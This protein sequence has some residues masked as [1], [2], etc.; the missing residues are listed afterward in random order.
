[1][2]RRVGSKLPHFMQAIIDELPSGN[3]R[4]E[5][6]QVAIQHGSK[7]RFGPL[8]PAADPP[9]QH[10]QD[11]GRAYSLKHHT[12]RCQTLLSSRE[13][14]HEQSPYALLHKQIDPLLS[15]DP[16]DPFGYGLQFSGSVF[17]LVGL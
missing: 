6:S 14:F 16:S 2:K 4:E 3:H 7:K 5:A 12:G 17:H 1:S 15:S 11:T 10:F 8:Q 9:P 13:R